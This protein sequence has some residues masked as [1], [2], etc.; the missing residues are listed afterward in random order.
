MTDIAEIHLKVLEK[1]NEKNNSVIL[2]CGYSKGISVKD[3]VEKFKKNTKK[4]VSIKILKK[5]RGDMAKIT[6]NTSK[7][8]KY[9]EWKPKF[10]NLDLIVKSCIKWE[11]RL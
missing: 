10:N 4:D 6:A 8:K 3:V 7:L 5:R 11:K 2:N 9:I 1:I